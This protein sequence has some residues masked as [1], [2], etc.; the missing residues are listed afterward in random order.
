M[1]VPPFTLVHSRRA[2]YGTSAIGV[3]SRGNAIEKPTVSGRGMKSIPDE[4]DRGVGARVASGVRARARA[5][6]TVGIWDVGA[7]V[8]RLPKVIAAL[9][10][11]QQE[12]EFYQVLSAVPAGLISQ[13]ERVRAWSEALGG[14]RRLPGLKRNVIAAD[15]F[16]RAER[17]RK[18]LPIDYLAGITASLIADEDEDEV[19]WNLF[20]TW[21]ARLVLVSS[22]QLREFAA[23]AERPFEAAVMGLVVAAL[24]A[25][26]HSRLR[27]HDDTGCLFDYNEKRADIVRV[28]RQPRIEDGCLE[29]IPTKHRAVALA[30]VRTLDRYG[31]GGCG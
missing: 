17:V 15:F 20:A 8:G 26:R 25:T 6:T 11:A 24:L 13:P 29:R 1:K 28:L 7:N 18:D 12:Y 4:A 3:T 30:I 10:R 21:S 23:K 14:T 31:R 19:Q 22:F 9:N 2:R 16:R 5:V 27:F